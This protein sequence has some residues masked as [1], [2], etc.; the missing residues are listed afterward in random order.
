VKKTQPNLTSGLA[1]EYDVKCGE[2]W[3]TQG[4]V[5]GLSIQINDTV[6]SSQ[7]PISGWPLGESN[8]CCLCCLY[9]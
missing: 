2:A 4:W 5:S 3:K 9:Q 8:L 7:H 6:T 1:L